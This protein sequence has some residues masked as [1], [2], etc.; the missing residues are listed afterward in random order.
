MKHAFLDANDGYY[1]VEVPEGRDPPAWTAS[2]TPTS[3]QPALSPTRSQWETA[4]KTSALTKLSR[5]SRAL[6]P[7]IVS[8]ADGDPVKAQLVAFRAA[9]P[10]LPYMTDLSSS[11]NEATAFALLEL[12]YAASLMA[13]NPPFS[14]TVMTEFQTEIGMAKA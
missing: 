10:I 9:L 1:E 7:M 13:V 5:T 3:V 8:R 6:L 4:A 12:A 14:S 2:L 11:T